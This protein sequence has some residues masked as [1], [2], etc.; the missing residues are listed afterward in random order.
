MSN[1][2]MKVQIAADA[3][4]FGA[5]WMNRVG[6]AVLKSMMYRSSSQFQKLML[7]FQFD[8]HYVVLETFYI[9]SPNK[10]T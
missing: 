10:T 5:P 1:A 2:S 8:Q 4:Y 3:V 7:E 6:T 9:D